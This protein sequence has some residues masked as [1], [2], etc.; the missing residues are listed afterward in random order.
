MQVFRAG[1]W[2]TIYLFDNSRAV[3][4]HHEHRYVGSCKQPPAVVTGNVNIAMATALNKLF[5]HW[6]EILDAWERGR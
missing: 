6:P 2:H 3:E 5:T 4:E 1:E